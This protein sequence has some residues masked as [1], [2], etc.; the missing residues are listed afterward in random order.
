M[1]VRSQDWGFGGLV[2]RRKI[3][4]HVLFG[5]EVYHRTAMETGEPG[6]TAFN[7]GM[8]IDFTEHQHLLFSAGRS[9]DGP[10]SSHRHPRVEAHRCRRQSLVNQRVH[11]PRPLR[12]LVPCV[13]VPQNP[14]FPPCALPE[15]RTSCARDGHPSH[16]TTRRRNVC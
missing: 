12:D 3:T 13:G 14:Q 11:H 8:A 2:V 5:A 7:V 15:A 9:I 1:N 10:K 16:N 4:E 6:D